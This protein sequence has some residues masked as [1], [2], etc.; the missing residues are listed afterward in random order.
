MYEG[1]RHL[2]LVV[3]DLHVARPE[4][5]EVLVDS[6]LQLII[7]ALA[8]ETVSISDVVIARRCSAYLATK[9][10]AS[11]AKRPCA[12]AGVMGC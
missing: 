2:V 3:I 5:R 4:G 7:G 6:E 12:L 11:G 10:Q 8:R 9:T 1:V